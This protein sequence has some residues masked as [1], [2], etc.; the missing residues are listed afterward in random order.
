MAQERPD[1]GE[2][3]EILGEIADADRRAGEVIARLR[4]FLHKGE[5]QLGPVDLNEVVCEV[6]TLTHTDLIRRRVTVDTTGLSPDLPGVFADRVQMQQVLLNLLL[7]ACDAILPDGLDR[8]VTIA[9]EAGADGTVECRWPIGERG[10]RR[11]RCR[12][13]SSRSS[14]RNPMG[15]A[16]ACRSAARSSRLTR[17]ACG[18]TTTGTGG[19]PS[20]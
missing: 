20:T 17:D 1:L 8:Q 2:V 14:P 6:L 13:S 11:R 5:L 12:T 10:Y 19:P 18:P 15:S 4:A 3:R 16:S 7:N 9:T